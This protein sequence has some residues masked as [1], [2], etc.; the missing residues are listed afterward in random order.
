[1]NRRG[2]GNVCISL[3]SDITSWVIIK[4]L[5]D[6]TVSSTLSHFRRRGRMRE[7]MCERGSR[8]IVGEG[9]E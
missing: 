7:L 1:V 4:K 5:N 2:E 9:T 8:V 3:L 6:I